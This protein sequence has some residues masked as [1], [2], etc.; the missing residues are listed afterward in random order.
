MSPDRDW[1]PTI[2]ELVDK[3][4]DDEL[5]VDEQSDLNQIL[6]Q[7][8]RQRSYYL[9]YTNF[10]VTLECKGRVAVP[11]VTFPSG[12]LAGTHMPPIPNVL[13]AASNRDQHAEIALPSVPP[14]SGFLGN[15]I[16]TSI[17]FLSSEWSVGYLVATVIFA[18]GLLVGSLVTVS[19]YTQIARNEKHVASRDPNSPGSA[20]RR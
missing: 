11:S 6:T 1:M 9:A 19:H 17:G 13:E 3:L 2:T 7:G 15:A 12:D 14:V 10:L 18:I 4:Y 8:S 5:S 16:H 20:C